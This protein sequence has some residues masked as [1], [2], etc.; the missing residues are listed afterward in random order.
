[1]DQTSQTIITIVCSVAASSGFWALLQ[2]KIGMNDA[3]TR[4]LIGLA[5]DRIITLG[6]V[7]IQRGY[8]TR[9]EYENLRD[10]LYEPYRKL[11]GNGS[12]CRIML[13]VDKLPIREHALNNK[14]E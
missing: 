13:E 14:G 6:M 7:Y 11:G 3:K 10:Y 5:H 1:M 9:D 12:A 4:M 8:I 2:S